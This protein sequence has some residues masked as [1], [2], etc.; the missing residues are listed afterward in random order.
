MKQPNFQDLL[1]ILLENNNE[2]LLKLEDFMKQ[3]RT[4]RFPNEI[5]QF[6]YRKR[7]QFYLRIP[8]KDSEQVLERDQDQT[9]E[10]IY[11]WLPLFPD[12]KSF[13]ITFF[14]FSP[15]IE[16]TP[17]QPST[18]NLDPTLDANVYNDLER[19]FDKDGSHHPLTLLS[20][21]SQNGDEPNVVPVGKRPSRTL[22]AILYRPRRI[23][24]IESA[25]AVE[26]AKKEQLEKV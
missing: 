9:T 11:D 21:A 19:K 7:N 15:F 20:F 16:E 18:T 2:N 23:I 24:E 3:F 14:S 5:I 17:E 25:H 6:P 10:Y 22:P 4:I 12:R 8:P 26:K 1:L 13:S